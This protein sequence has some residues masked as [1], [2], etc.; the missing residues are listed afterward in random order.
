[1]AKIISFATQKGGS[2]KSTLVVLTASALAYRKNLKIKILD[3]DPQQTVYRLYQR[4][5]PTKID[6]E[7]FDWEHSKADARFKEL[8]AKDDANYDII[9]C[10]I[11]GKLGGVSVFYPILFSDV[12]AVPLVASLFDMDSTI[13]FLKSLPEVMEKRKNAGLDFTILGIP[14]QKARTLEERSITGIKGKYD[15]DLMETGLS[16]LVRYKRNISLLEPLLE[17]SDTEDEFNLYIK[18]FIKKCEL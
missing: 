7:F 18:E 17:D 6:V 14:N 10:D 3:T 1:M 8:L 16:N 11:P 4:E 9:F 13:V 5:N 2:G 12:V 15:L